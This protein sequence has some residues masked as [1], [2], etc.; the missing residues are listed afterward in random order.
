MEEYRIPSKKGIERLVNLTN[1]SYSTMPLLPTV[2]KHFAGIRPPA[3]K[4]SV[5]NWPADPDGYNFNA[6]SGDFLKLLK[7]VL[8]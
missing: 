3:P 5:R 1:L 8:S 2:M 6:V 4:N 7:I